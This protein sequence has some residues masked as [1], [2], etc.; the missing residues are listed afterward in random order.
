MRRSMA[1]IPERR[2]SSDELSQLRMQNAMQ[3]RPPVQHYQRKLA[4]PVLLGFFYVLS[5]LGL[6]LLVGPLLFFWKPLSRHHACFMILI[7]LLELLVAFLALHNYL[8]NVENIPLWIPEWLV[9]LA[10]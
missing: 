7:S 9:N 10:L 4:P 2:R 5:A 1:N 3:L 8:R 6:G